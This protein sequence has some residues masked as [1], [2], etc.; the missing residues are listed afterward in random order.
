MAS[1]QLS[2]SKINLREA[3]ANLLQSDP[4]FATRFADAEAIESPQ[5]WGL[6]LAARQ[7][8]NFG[9]NYLL[10]GDAG[11]LIHP[12]SGEG[13]GSAMLSGFAAAQYAVR[14]LDSRRFEAAALQN[15]QVETTRRMQSEI[16][17]YRRV[18]HLNP[19]MWQNYF[20]NG[21][22]GSGLAKPLFERA[23]K[24]WV[25]TAFNKPIIVQF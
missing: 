9:D 1:H 3:F 25:D 7:R 18:A 20:F 21:I 23:A 12:L 17:I 10:A 4:F 5:G 19:A 11:S 24:K 14:A 13:I 22:I 2:K 15:F 8:K 16:N 6:P